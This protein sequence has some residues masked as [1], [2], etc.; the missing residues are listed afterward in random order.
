[1]QTRSFFQRGINR[2]M[3]A[4]FA[5]ALVATGTAWAQEAAAPV[6]LPTRVDPSTNQLL[7]GVEA[8]GTRLW[9]SLDT[10]FSALISLDR[11]KA[12]RAGISESAAPP[13]PDGNRPFNGDGSAKVTLQ[14]GPITMRDQPVII[15][16]LSTNAPDMDCVMGAALLRTHVIE[17]DYE[18][19]RV[20]LHTA[21]GFTAPPG[22]A[23]VPLIFR[24]NP[25]VPFVSVHV[26]LADGSSRDLQTVVD[27]GTTF[28]ALAVAPPAATW[29]REHSVTAP[30]PGQAETAGGVLQLVAAR[31]RTV[32]VGPFGVTE[33]LIALVGGGLRGV[34]D[35]LLGV[36]FLRRFTVWM[37]FNGRAMYLAP[38]RNL[39]APH[40]FDASGLSLKRVADGYEVNAVLPGSPAATADIRAGDRLIAIEGR[41]RIRSVSPRYKNA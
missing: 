18:A 6:T 24:T 14:V 33:P 12:R 2:V 22:A 4:C 30:I 15:R 1:M 23:T 27:T 39:K 17:F 34:D 29:M 41:R 7:I 26:D 31:P 38:N 5:V 13:T 36:G 20:R 16:E 19:P 10:G 40:L 21:A 3:L 9:C 25:S 8:K 35:G 28:Y 11:A 37:D 32:K